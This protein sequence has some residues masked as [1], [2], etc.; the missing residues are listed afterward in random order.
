MEEKIQQ[1]GWTFLAPDGYINLREEM[2]PRKLR[3][4]VAIDRPRAAI[5]RLIYRWYATGTTTLA[6]IAERLEQL[7]ST[8]IALGKHG[9][10]ASRGGAWYPQKIWAILNNRFYVG[11]VSVPSWKYVGSG[12]HPPIISTALFQRVQEVLAIYH[13]PLNAHDYL[14][15]GR[16]WMQNVPL[17]CTLVKR[18]QRVYRY[19]YRILPNRKRTYYLADPIEY[20]VISAIRAHVATLGDAPAQ[21]LTQRL[22]HMA[23]QRHTELAAHVNDLQAARERLIHLAARGRFSDAEVDA[24]LNR[25]EHEQTLIQVEQQQIDQL[26][27]MQAAAVSQM[28][29]IIDTLHQWDEVSCEQQC[30]T[31]Q[32]CI[33]RIVLSE[34]QMV[35]HIQWQPL[36]QLVWYPDLP[37][38]REQV[39]VYS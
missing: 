3:S 26:M 17:C 1:G 33:E 2:A 27:T 30:I 34:D 36:W 7:H 32:A 20:K 28:V 4:W 9:C 19:Y 8:R 21:T 18:P 15:Q 31:I 29:T 6:Q 39:V 10:R 13:Q 22:N 37:L 23:K 35:E 14:L 5:I 25:L 38:E 12:V 16:L 24:E 11:E